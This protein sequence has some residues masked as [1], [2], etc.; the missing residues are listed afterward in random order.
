MWP[1]SIYGDVFA[2]LFEKA[3]VV[4]E[5]RKPKHLV[6]AVTSDRGL[7]G[8]IH[9]S[10]AKNIRAIMADRSSEASTQIV[11]VGDK[12]R[13]IMQRFFPRNLLMHF[14]D[15]GKKPPRFVEASYV[16]QQVLDSGVEYDSA[17]LIFNKF[18]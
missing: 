10:V 13:T 9:S 6:I 16:A 4:E 5:D 7:C 12:V 15:I 1:W 2:A 8:G 17:E 11:C 3:E 14:S 18:K